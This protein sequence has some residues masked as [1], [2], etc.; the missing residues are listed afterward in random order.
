MGDKTDALKS[1]M[2]AQGIVVAGV[3]CFGLAIVG[4]LSHTAAYIYASN[5]SE[6]FT[7]TNQT[8]L[9]GEDLKPKSEFLAGDGIN[10]RYHVHLEPIDCYGLY[11]HR[12]DGPVT[13]QFDET[14]TGPSQVSEPT[15]MVTT[16]HF[17]LPRHLPAG[18][19]KVRLMAFPTCEGLDLQP[20]NYDLGLDLAVLPS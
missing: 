12:L 14:R 9:L 20:K 3:I 10:L 5:K 18:D 4:A 7:I 6:L 1:F 19:Y 13:Y 16:V 2:K 11:V 17:E 8:E 15:D